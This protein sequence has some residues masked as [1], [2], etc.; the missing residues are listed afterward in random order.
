MLIEKFHDTAEVMRNHYNIPK[1]KWYDFIILLDSQVEEWVNIDNREKYP[2][3]YLIWNDVAII[4]RKS[5]LI[6]TETLS[7]KVWA[8]SFL[9]AIEQ[10]LLN[11]KNNYKISDISQIEKN[12]LILKEGLANG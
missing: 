7:W 12:I 5:I 9:G 1:S 6:S 10:K 3:Q 8:Y 11:F 4:L 2:I